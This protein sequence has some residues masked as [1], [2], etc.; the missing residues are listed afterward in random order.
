MHKIMNGVSSGGGCEPRLKAYLMR[1][2]RERARREKALGD[3]HRVH[4][5]IFLGFWTPSPLVPMS[6][7]LLARK[8]GQFLGPLA[9]PPQCGGTSWKPLRQS[10][11]DNRQHATAAAAD[12][13]RLL[14]SDLGRTTLCPATFYCLRRGRSHWGPRSGP[15]I[16]QKVGPRLRECPGR[17]SQQE[18][19]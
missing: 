5:L 6:A 18:Q 1:H 14:S 12:C 15:G 9:L 7:E 13:G 3:F 2:P 10:G 19:N 17:Y 8:T 16:G 4:P 11:K